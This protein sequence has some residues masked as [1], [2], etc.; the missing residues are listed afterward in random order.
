MWGSS[1]AN[2]GKKLAEKVCATLL[3]SWTDWAKGWMLSQCQFCWTR[4]WGIG[5]NYDWQWKLVFSIQ[6]WNEWQSIAWHGTSS[7]AEGSHVSNTACQTNADCFSNAA[8]IIHCGFV[9]EGTSQQSLLFRIKEMSVVM[10]VLCQQRAGLKQQLG[11]AAMKMCLPTTHWRAVSCCQIDLHD[12]ASP[13]CQIWQQQTF[14]VPNVKLALKGGHF[15]DTERHQTWCHQATER[16]FISGF[17]AHIQ[18][19]V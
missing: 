12:P 1:Q 13:T 8:R 19:P 16:G 10:H 5:K 6:T 4:L 14:L 11:A 7:L 17:P 18:A 9:P 2:F 3:N 15:G